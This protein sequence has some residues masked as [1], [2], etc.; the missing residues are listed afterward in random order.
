MCSKRCRLLHAA[1]A[2][3]HIPL[4]SHPPRAPTPG[5]SDLTTW[6]RVVRMGGREHV[7]E[8]G[9]AVGCKEDV[10]VEVGAGSGAAEV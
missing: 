2:I 7:S 10:V 6:A 1:R 9:V 8:P 4:G 3:N 5:C